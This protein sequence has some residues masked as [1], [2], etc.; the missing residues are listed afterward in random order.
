MAVSDMR[1]SRNRGHRWLI[2]GFLWALFI[3]TIAYQIVPASIFP[4]IQTALSI[5]PTAASWTVSILFL[6]MA[7]FAIPAGMAL[8]HFDDRKVLT[9]ATSVLLLTTIWSWYAGTNANYLSLL[10]SRFVGGFAAST[11]WTGSVNAIGN[12]VPAEKQATAIG[13]YSTATPAGLSLGLFSGPFIAVRSGWEMTFP[14]YG[15]GAALA[16]VAFLLVSRGGTYTYRP[17]ATASRRD[18]RRV[19]LDRGVLTVSTLGFIALSLFMFFNNWMPSYIVTTFDY[20]LEQSGI[21]AAVFPAIG[22]VS[23]S[24]SGVISDR[25]LGQRRKPLVFVSF[26]VALPVIIGI[27]ISTT[28]VVVLLLLLAAGF[29][30]QIAVAI[31]FTYVRELVDRQVVGTAL[32]MLN[33]FAF[34]GGFAT[35]ILTGWLIER[36]GSYST[37]FVYAGLLTI[38][39]VAITAVVPESD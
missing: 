30:V 25:W 8:D 24:L 21:L 1:A 20:S 33:A 32:A 3:F 17:S 13:I 37:A 6:S 23:R 2:I 31:L 26:L 12:S 39:G 10:A 28:I 19:F 11:I 38:C 9:V 7:L 18:F 27:S 36:S 35:P 15:I 14:V 22:I 34:F 29:F 4:T 5:G 16:C